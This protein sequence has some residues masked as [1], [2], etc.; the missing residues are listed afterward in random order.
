M[1]LFNPLFVLKKTCIVNHTVHF[2]QTAV[3]LQ[4]LETDADPGTNTQDTPQNAGF[5]Q[6]LDPKT[7][8]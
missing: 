3:G 5:Y 1:T 7:L 2:I 4:S 6:A 8:D